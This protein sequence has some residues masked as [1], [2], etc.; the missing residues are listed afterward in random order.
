M[1]QV[2]CQ[3]EAGTSCGL[4]S[5]SFRGSWALLPCCEGQ[6]LWGQV[7][8]HEPLFMP[9]FFS[10]PFLSSYN[11]PD[12]GLSPSVWTHWAL[13]PRPWLLRVMF[14]ENWEVCQG[15]HNTHKKS[16]ENPS[17][18]MHRCSA[19]RAAA[20]ATTFFWGS[21]LT[22]YHG[23]QILGEL[24]AGVQRPCQPGYAIVSLLKLHSQPGGAGEEALKRRQHRCLQ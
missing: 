22:L 15:R 9:S 7:W 16:L 8:K 13:T 18:V 3:R 1:G 6:G 17:E 23:I 19:P 4:G 5:W 24:T 10:R 11:V 20:G 14:I 12:T 2:V 21:D